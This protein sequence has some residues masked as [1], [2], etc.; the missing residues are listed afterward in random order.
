MHATW[1]EKWEK[2]SFFLRFYVLFICVFFLVLVWFFKWQN[3]RTLAI[4]RLQQSDLIG[5]GDLGGV[6]HTKM[7]GAQGGGSKGLFLTKCLSSFNN[8]RWLQKIWLNLSR[9]GTK[10]DTNIPGGGKTEREKGKYFFFKL[11]FLK[12]WSK[13]KQQKILFFLYHSIFFF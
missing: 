5:W 7:G 1:W 9:F 4:V 10:Y 11:R 8:S 6:A 13:E 2:E 3:W 12:D